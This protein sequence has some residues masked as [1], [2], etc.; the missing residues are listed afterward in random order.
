MV[1][2]LHSPRLMWYGGKCSTQEKMSSVV[3]RRDSVQGP[4]WLI[5]NPL[6]GSTSSI[7]PL[8]T[9]VCS[10][11]PPLE[12]NVNECKYNFVYRPF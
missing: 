12:P 8:T 5:F 7:S 6:P 3:Q 11:L 2:L 9:L 10:S 4:L 1:E